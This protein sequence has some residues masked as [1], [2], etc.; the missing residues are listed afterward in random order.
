MANDISTSGVKNGP[1]STSHDSGETTETW[2]SRHTIKVQASQP[3]GQRLTTTWTSANGA[4]SRA[5]ERFPNETDE[6][7]LLRHIFDYMDLM[8]VEP[9]ID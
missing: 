4:Q 5:T 9:P 2:V 6:S 8:A 1:K 3:N 7:F